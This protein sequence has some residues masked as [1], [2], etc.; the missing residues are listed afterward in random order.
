MNSKMKKFELNGK[1]LMKS[2]LSLWASVLLPL[3][4]VFGISYLG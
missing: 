1:S 4:I 2:L 3:L